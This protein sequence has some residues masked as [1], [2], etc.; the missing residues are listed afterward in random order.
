MPT[1]RDRQIYVQDERC[2]G[3]EGGSCEG[4]NYDEEVIDHMKSKNQR[5]IVRQ[6]LEKVKKSVLGLLLENV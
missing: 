1:E 4:A 3:E 6:S 5:I 2:T